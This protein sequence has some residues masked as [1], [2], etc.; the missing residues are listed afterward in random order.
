MSDEIKD[1][2]RILGEQMKNGGISHFILLVLKKNPSYGYKI[3]Q[4]IEKRTFGI[5]NPS[6]STIYRLLDSLENKN[7]IRVLEAEEEGR[8]RKI[9]EITLEGEKTLEVL[10]DIYEK[11]QEAMRRMIFSS[12]QLTADEDLSKIINFLPHKDPIYGI[13]SLKNE[14]DKIK[15]L[16]IK[17]VMIKQRIREMRLGIRHIDIAIEKLKNRIKK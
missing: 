9:Y 1:K 2:A 12:M 15:T 11:M 8:Q 4:E 10:I 3:I 6:T 16:E 14:E 5:W 13:E 7:L 17:K